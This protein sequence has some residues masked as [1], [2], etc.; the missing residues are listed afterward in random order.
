MFSEYRVPSNRQILMNVLWIQA[1]LQQTVTVGYSLSTSC[2]PTDSYCWMFSEYKL[3]SNRQLLL[4]VL[5]VQAALQ[6]PWSLQQPR[7]VRGALHL[8][9]PGNS[10]EG[11]VSQ[12]LSM[13]KRRLP[14]GC[15]NRVLD[16]LRTIGN[17]YSPIGRFR[18]LIKDVKFVLDS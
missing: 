2:P 3:P 16:V 11:G 10:V 8:L 6:L 9:L 14:L 13:I 4:D 1:A 17:I 18:R 12:V 5:W 15:K 7:T